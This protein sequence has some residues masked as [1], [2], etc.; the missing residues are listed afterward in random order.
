MLVVASVV[1]VLELAEQAQHA[2][3]QRESEAVVGAPR[4]AAGLQKTALPIELLEAG[5]RAGLPSLEGAHGKRAGCGAASQAGGER[6]GA[7]GLS[8]QLVE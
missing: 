3:G 2:G 5:Q 8:P 7:P 1:P 6:T 4:I